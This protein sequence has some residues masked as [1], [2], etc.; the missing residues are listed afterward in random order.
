MYGDFMET[1]PETNALIDHNPERGLSRLPFLLWTGIHQSHPI[2]YERGMMTAGN[3]VRLM[4]WFFHESRKC[5]GLWR[6][7]FNSKNGIIHKI[8]IILS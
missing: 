3:K 5:N 2:K 7:H 6:Q 8:R 4:D 1:C